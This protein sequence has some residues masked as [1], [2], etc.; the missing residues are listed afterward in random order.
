M[1]P[2]LDRISF[3]VHRG[4]AFGLVGESGS[5]KSMTARSITRLLPPGALL[6]GDAS[7]AGRSTVTMSA[8]ELRTVRSRQV[9]MIFQDPRAHI[10]PVRRMGDYLTEALVTNRGLA[11]AEA[12][13]QVVDVL[14]AIGVTDA[15]ARLSQY[16]H[17]LSGGLLQRMMI[18]AAIVAE[19]ELL[20]A[21]E[22][23]TALDV[24]TQRGVVALL[25][26]LRRERGLTLIFIT[27][28]LDLAAAICDRTAVMYAGSVVEVQDSGKLHT[29]P[30]HP[31]SAA[32]VAA[33]PAFTS[34]LRPLTIPGAPAS[35]AEA[36]PGCQFMPRCPYKV[37]QCESHRPRLE[38]SGQ[39]SVACFRSG[40]IRD[41][42][43]KIASRS[44]HG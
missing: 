1:Q 16:P 31:Y 18:A 8:K 23:T 27:H 11:R 33:R 17:E 4:E 34:G 25:D 29:Q 2:I 12:N 14:E 3:T 37:K 19:P 5:G 6:T 24:T 44:S 42:L 22:P 36:G 39:G 28:D 13:R 15:R 9:Q 26:A 43:A 32:L 30:M 20:I 35:L 7:L 38:K 41:D 21:D 40:E 10:D